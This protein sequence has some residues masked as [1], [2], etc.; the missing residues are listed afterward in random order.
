MIS[1]HLGRFYT[2]QSIRD[3]ARE[4]IM[5]RERPSVEYLR[6]L[7]SAF[8][9]RANNTAD[10]VR[11]SVYQEIAGVFERSASEGDAELVQYQA[12]GLGRLM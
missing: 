10:P 3:G 1:P 9:I 12:G 4:N 6:L 8:R 2:V 7:A 11:A 5:E